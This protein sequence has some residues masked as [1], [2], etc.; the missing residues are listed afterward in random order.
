MLAPDLFSDAVI[1]S[2]HAVSSRH[3]CSTVLEAAVSVPEAARIPVAPKVVFGRDWHGLLLTI[4]GGGM[5][6]G[7]GGL[8][9]L[10]Q[11]GTKVTS[12]FLKN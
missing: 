3:S 9:L 5:L 2:V 10:L 6:I 7:G 11:G 12:Q 8:V 1:L 4:E